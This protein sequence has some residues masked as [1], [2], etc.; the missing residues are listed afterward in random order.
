[1]KAVHQEE[2]A[3]PALQVPR[4]QVA[5]LALLHEALEPPPDVRVNLVEATGRVAG[6]EVVAPPA[7]HGVQI[8]HDNAHVLHAVAFAAGQLLHALPHTLQAARGRLALEEVGATALLLP[9]RT[10][11]ALAQVAAEE[12]EAVLTTTEID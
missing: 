12:V 11:Q 4:V 3:V 7:K 6:R 1:M 2:I 10:A 5:S 9:D 8:A